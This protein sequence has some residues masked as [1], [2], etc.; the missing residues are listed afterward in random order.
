MLKKQYRMDKWWSKLACYDVL[1]SDS[2]VLHI[3][4]GMETEDWAATDEDNIVSWQKLNLVS[5]WYMLRQLLGTRWW[6]HSCWD[7]DDEKFL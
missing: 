4:Y 7:N 6:K 2:I 5:H 1:S 3:T